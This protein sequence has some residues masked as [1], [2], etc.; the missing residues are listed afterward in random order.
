MVWGCPTYFFEPKMQ[1]PRMK[2]PKWDTR[3]QIEVNMGFSN[4]SSTQFGLVLNLFTGS[5]SPQYRVV[6]DYMFSTVVI[7][8]AIDP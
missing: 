3:I 7:S 1:N 6:L 2:I 8:K 4:T 5:I